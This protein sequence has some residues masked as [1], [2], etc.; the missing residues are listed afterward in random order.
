MKTLFHTMYLVPLLAWSMLAGSTAEARRRSERDGFN[1]GTSVRLLT[2]DNATFAG[3][4]STKNTTVKTSGQAL[5]PFVGY[6]V[7]GLLNFGLSFHIQQQ[8]TEQ[9]TREDDGS[10]E[11]TLTTDTDTK[12]ASIFTRFMFGKV[13]FMEGGLGLYKTV[14]NIN[15]ETLTMTGTGTYSGKSEAAEIYGVGPGYH[16]GGGIEIPITDGFY[17]TS[18][19]MVRIFQVR[20]YDGAATFGTK[21]GR[22]QQRE[23]SFGLEH[24][25]N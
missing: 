6:A 13:M 10:S 9:T 8:S 19:Y 3:E 15:N 23:L 4:N 22:Q 25:L 16:V 11:S 12:G 18:A 1:F 7:N 24:F 14:T 21:I 20:E 5:D 17:F 2:E